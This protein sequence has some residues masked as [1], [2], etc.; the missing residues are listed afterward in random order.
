MKINTNMILSWITVVVVFYF[1]AA[2]ALRLVIPI[3]MNRI[4]G[5]Q[6]PP[7][8]GF[9]RAIT[10]GFVGFIVFVCYLLLNKTGVGIKYVNWF[11]NVNKEIID[12]IK[13]K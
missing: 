2:I 9:G 5:L 12:N 13:N 7:N 8:N 4:F 3:V 6:Y 10:S 11:K 1:T